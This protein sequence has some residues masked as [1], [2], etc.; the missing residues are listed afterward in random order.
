MSVGTTTIIRRALSDL[1][2]ETLIQLKSVAER[3]DYPPKTK[4]CH[5]GEIEHT[6]YVI[7]EG[8]VA[9][10]QKLENGSERLLS[11]LRNNDY[12]G[13]M[14][15]V[16]D[17][18]RI[19]DA[20][21]I[22]DTTVL[23]V[24][25]ASFDRFVKQSPALAQ[26]ITKKILSTARTRDQLNI[27]E[28]QIKNKELEQAYH[29]LKEAQAKLIEQERI[30]RELELAADMQKSLLP[31]SLPQFDNYHFEAYLK[32]A[33]DVGGDFYDVI[34]LEN[35]HV[36][37][38]IADVADKGIHA[39]LFMAVVRTLFVIE[40]KRSLSPAEVA[41]RVH[42]ALFGVTTT[43]SF[44]TVFYGVVHRPT[45][46]LSYVRAS[47]DRPILAKRD[48]TLTELPGNGRFLGMLEDLQLEEYEI[49][50]E[51]GD[52]LI[53]YSDGVT[54]AENENKQNYGI[55]R[56]KKTI[57]FKSNATADEV[58]KLIRQDVRHWMGSAAP[59]DDFTLLVMEAL[60]L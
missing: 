43:D 52:R 32:P 21:T 9:V 53:M 20:V 18:P 36:G 42:H 60:E 54:D 1:D 34:D 45:G 8:N 22:T 16:D 58:V 5:Q 23:E 40:S 14:S 29:D 37:V 17:S 51:S 56:L 15:L 39:A 57:A 44:V 7:V 46:R 50:L 3:R 28:L 33:R 24:T 6:F 25:E 31:E 47:H 35:E 55:E 4:L 59:I 38:L 2:E 10:S 11:I 41:L 12:F 30:Q 27:K 19:A 13:E 26:L 49:M 48:G